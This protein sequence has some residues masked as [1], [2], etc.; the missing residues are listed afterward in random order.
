[1]TL[2]VVLQISLVVEDFPAGLARKWFL[3]CVGPQVAGHM[4]HA[5]ALPTGGAGEGL[6]F[7]VEAQMNAQAAAGAATPT[8][9]AGGVFF[10]AS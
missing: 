6:L 2:L 1:M 5:A 8:D 3:T 4:T 10:T 9:L 7:G